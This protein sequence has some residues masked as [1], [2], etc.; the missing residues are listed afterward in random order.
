M[1][2]W[3][4]LGYSLSLSQSTVVGSLG[5]LDTIPS[6]SKTCSEG[7]MGQTLSKK[8]RLLIE[9]FKGVAGTVKI[10]KSNPLSAGEVVQFSS[11]IQNTY[12]RDQS[13]RM[14]SLA[15]SIIILYF[16][17]AMGLEAAPH[18]PRHMHLHLVR[19]PPPAPA[20]HIMVETIEA[21]EAVDKRSIAHVPQESMI[22]AQGEYGNQRQLGVGPGAQELEDELTLFR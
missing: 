6:P 17:W 12:N 5:C 20:P 8:G 10:Y 11:F 3:T 14:P 22:E 1:N 7:V 2:M 21:T 9:P 15:V 19:S 18:Q 16:L 4:R 13:A